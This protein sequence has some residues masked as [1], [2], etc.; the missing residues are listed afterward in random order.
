LLHAGNSGRGFSNAVYSGFDNDFG[1]GGGGGGG[2]IGSDVAI[3][4]ARGG[5]RYGIYGQ[6]INLATLGTPRLTF[7]NGPAGGTAGAVLVEHQPQA[8]VTVG[9]V[10]ALQRQETVVRALMARSLAAAEVAV[11]LPELAEQ[12]VQVEQAAL[13]A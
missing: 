4:G 12:Q 2:Y 9:A 13:A 5:K 11:A 8:A 1:G 7:G 10:V 6:Q 3:A